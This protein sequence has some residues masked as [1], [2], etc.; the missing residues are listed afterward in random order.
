MKLCNILPRNYL[1]H[2][3]EFQLVP[4]AFSVILGDHFMVNGG[5][6]FQKKYFYVGT[7]F[8]GKIYRGIV[9]H[10]GLMIR[11]REKE[12]YKMYFPVT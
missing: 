6:F 8:V 5:E 11:R 1:S 7:N 3:F 10:G 12:F 2:R 4:F 9:L